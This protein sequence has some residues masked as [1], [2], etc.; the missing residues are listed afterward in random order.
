MQTTT[1]SIIVNTDD[2][3][4][5]QGLNL[6]LSQEIR[7]FLQKLKESNEINVDGINIKLE[8]LKLE[9]SI[10]EMA[11]LQA[12]IQAIE[13]RIERHEKTQI[14][15]EEKKL[16]D[17]KEELEKQTSCANCHKIIDEE[18]KRDVKKGIILCNVCVQDKDV[19]RKYL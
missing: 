15:T 13:S 16:K 14:K 6:N 1:K 3:K 18:T 8:R 11:H 7:E 4:Y 9:S 10:K 17:E 12:N 5:L 2:W 19:L